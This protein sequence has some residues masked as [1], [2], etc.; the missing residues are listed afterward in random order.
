MPIYHKRVNGRKVWW[1]RVA[2]K[3]LTAS[4]ICET[5]TIAQATHDELRQDL[6]RRAARAEEQGLGLARLGLRIIT[7]AC[8]PHQFT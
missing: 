7:P 5:K 2:H 1:V 3:G 6:R 4:R 8:W